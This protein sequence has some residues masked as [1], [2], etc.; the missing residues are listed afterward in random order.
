MLDST[1]LAVSLGRDNA[2]AIYSYRD[3]YTEPSFE[4][5]IPAGSF[6]S[7][8]A[9]DTQLHRLVIASEQGLGSVGPNGTVSEGLGTNPATSHMGYNFVGTVQTVASPTP[10]QMAA[11]TQQ[12]FKNNQWIGLRARN[13]QGNSNAQPVAVP[14]RTGDPSTIKHVFLIVKENRTYDQVLGDDP[15][16]NGDPSL[17]QFGGKTTPNTHALATHLPCPAHARCAASS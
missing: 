12:V 1:H 9:E 7:G 14:L 8:L 16:G 5:L 15:R 17:A 4:G 6:P 10:T 2:V 13:Q 3:A 11:W